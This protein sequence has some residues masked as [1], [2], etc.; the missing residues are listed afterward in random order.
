MRIAIVAWGSLVWRPT[1]RGV[2]LRLHTADDWRRDGPRLP[3]EFARVSCDGSLTLV[4]VPGY[5]NRVTTLWSVSAYDNLNDAIRNLASREGITKN[6]DPIHGVFRSGLPIGSVDR[7]I[8]AAVHGWLLE[9]QPL[10]AAIWTGLGTHPTRWH[11]H[12]YEDG[13]TP[14]NAISYLRSLRGD[15]GHPAFEYVMKAPA[16]ITTPVRQR[17][18]DERII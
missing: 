13:F 16:Q 10:D 3:V 14:D 5:P 9:H 15:P 4:V 18:K 8:A 7:N 1:D 2:R 17:A 11:D 6:L 12:G